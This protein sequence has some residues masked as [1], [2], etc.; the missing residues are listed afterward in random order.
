MKRHHELI[1]KFVEDSLQSGIIQ[2]MPTSF[3]PW[4]QMPIMLVTNR[5]AR[6]CHDG[7]VSKKAEHYS[8]PVKME[9]FA[10]IFNCCPRATPF[11]KLDDSK[12][13]NQ[14][15]IRTESRDLC[16]F[17][18][19][20]RIFTYRASNFGEPKHPACYQRANMVLTNLLR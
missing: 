9:S 16:A 15:W 19:K 4:I 10:E 5:K 17:K 3:K 2:L 8:T 11:C 12:G 6:M 20:N 1:H 7:G 18:W 13:F 14:M